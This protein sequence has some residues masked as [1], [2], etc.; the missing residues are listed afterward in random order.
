MKTELE[1]N[2]CNNFPKDREF[3]GWFCQG[4]GNV[5]CK[6]VR[7][8]EESGDLLYSWFEVHGYDSQELIAWAEVPKLEL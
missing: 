1:I 6:V 2:E 8:E 4:R 5:A 7:Y 3:I